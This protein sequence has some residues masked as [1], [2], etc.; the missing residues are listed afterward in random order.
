MSQM[1]VAIVGASSNRTKFGTRP[2][3]LTRREGSRSIPSIQPRLW[4]RAYRP[5]ALCWTSLGWWIRILTCRR[6]WSPGHRG[7]DAQGRKGAMGVRR[8]TMV[9]PGAE[10]PELQEKARALGPRSGSGLQHCGCG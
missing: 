10:S 4:L 7:S 3:A 8:R 5:I 9:S 1:S 6:R 2:C